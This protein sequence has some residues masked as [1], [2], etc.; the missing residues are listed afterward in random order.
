MCVVTE[1]WFR[2]VVVY[3]CLG[4]GSGFDPSGLDRPMMIRQATASAGAMR[5]EAGLPRRVTLSHPLQERLWCRRAHSDA[6]PPNRWRWGGEAAG[7]ALV[8]GWSLEGVL[9]PLSRY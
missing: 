4:L 2:D 7:A 6:H 3:Y 5:G 9:S 1:E 8:F